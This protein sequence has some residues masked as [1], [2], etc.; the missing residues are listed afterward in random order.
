MHRRSASG[1]LAKPVWPGLNRPLTDLPDQGNCDSPVCGNMQKW[2]GPACARTMAAH[3]TSKAACDAA[4]FMCRA[5]PIH[6]SSASR[7]ILACCAH[8]S[9]DCVVCVRRL[10]TLGSFEACAVAHLS[11]TP[12]NA[13]PF[14]LCSPMNTFMAAVEAYAGLVVGDDSLNALLES[15][16]CQPI[17]AITTPNH[18]S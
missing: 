14:L 7:R 10:E 17:S 9:T 12:G 4:R 13:R 1:R 15:R 6:R 3:C 18:P 5:F 16:R 2:G 11:H 8:R